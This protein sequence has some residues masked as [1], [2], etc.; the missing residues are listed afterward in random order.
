MPAVQLTDLANHAYVL[1][2]DLFVDL[3]RSGMSGIELRV[4]DALPVFTRLDVV[5]LVFGN[6]QF[7]FEHLGLVGTDRFHVAF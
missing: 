2:V 3:V 4:I 1:G 7:M 5:A 6:G